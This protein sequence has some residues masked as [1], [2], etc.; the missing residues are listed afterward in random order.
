MP[1]YPFGSCAG[2]VCL[3]A[4]L[5]CVP[6]ATSGADTALA[7]NAQRN[8]G[9]QKASAS[10]VH[11]WLKGREKIE[12]ESLQAR[13]P[14]PQGF[15]RVTLP[16][17]SFGTWLRALPMKPGSAPVMLHSGAR[18]WRQDVHA[19]VIDID[20]GRRDLQQCADAIMRLRAEWL[21][22]DGRKNEIAFNYTGGGR[23][24]FSRW[25]RGERPS[26]S[27]KSWRR[28]SKRDASYASFKRY[29]VQIFA[30]AGTYSLSKE[31]KKI[32]P[33]AMQP[34][35]VF[36]KGGFPGHAVLVA[37]MVENPSTGEKRFL[38]LQSFMPAQDMHI[39]T[40]PRGANH[41]HW[42]P[43]KFDWP[44]VTPEWTF[45]NGSLKRWP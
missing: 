23:V 37:D 7:D 26:E 44:L 43:A 4:L 24:P 29:L 14:P 1:P 22:Q 21:W 15:V 9:S 13:F 34:G 30:Y 33:A 39:I 19:G 12:R 8:M 10:L 2:A 20:T 42:Y 6:A 35:D 36:I 11:P 31:L 28:R 25:A 3:G 32:D 41:D 45:P 17:D 27:G 5:C 16:S 38:L 40:A 18:K